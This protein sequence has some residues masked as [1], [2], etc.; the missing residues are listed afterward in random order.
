MT[1]P[2]ARILGR[3]ILLQS[4]LHLMTDNQAM[5]RFVWRGLAPVPG[6]N[7]TGM[8]ITGRL[9]RQDEASGPDDRDCGNLMAC[10]SGAADSST[11]RENYLAQFRK[12][13][14]VDCLPIESPFDLYGFLFFQITDS[15]IFAAYRPYIE[16]TLNLVALIIESNK[17]KRLLHQHKE[18]LEQ[19]VEARTRELEQSEEKY[20][21]LFESIRDAILVTDTNR[22]IIS[23]N[24]AVTDLFGYGRE[25]LKGNDIKLLCKD[26]NQYADL[27][28]SLQQEAD[29]GKA[30]HV[31]QYRKKSGTCFQGETNFFSFRDTKGEKVGIIGIIR[32]IT[33]RL[34]AGDALR[35]SEQRFRELFNSISD[36][37]FTQDLEGRLT[38]VNPAMNKGFGYTEEELLG[39]RVSDFMD[40]KYRPAFDSEY[41]AGIRKSGRSKGVS[42]FFRKDGSRIYIEYRSKL[43]TPNQGT[44]FIS[45]IGQDVSDRILAAKERKRLEAQLRQSQKMESIGTLSGGIAHDFNNMLSI[46]LGHTELAF[47]KIPEDSPAREFLCEVQTAGMRAR[48]VV[49]QLLTFSRKTPEA[50]EPLNLV[51]IVKEC[52]KLLRSTIAA[53]ID[54]RPDIDE[55]PAVL[56]ADATQIQQVLINLCSNA[57]DA[58]SETGGILRVSLA[59]EDLSRETAEFDPDLSA[60]HF[61]KITVRDTGEGIAAEH[62]NRIF[63]PYFTTKPV[64]KGTGMGLAMV[65]GIVKS[66]GGSI[67]VSSQPERGSVFEVFFPAVESAPKPGRSAFAE[68][69]RGTGRILLIE[70][71]PSLAGLNQ[72]RLE[73]LGYHADSQ[74][75][76]VEA[77]ELFRASPNLYDLVITDMTMPNMTGDQLCREILEIRPDMAIILCTGFSEKISEAS[78]KSLGAA[79]YLEKP[80]SM[81]DLAQS[82]HTLLSVP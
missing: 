10:L 33:W 45:G 47:E 43:V 49:R 19:A 1:D 46:I 59:F 14:Q 55:R 15:E 78:A 64:N 48:D 80:I 40:P 65:H 2:D 68:L 56:E 74:T 35:Q 11:Q 4:T 28:A 69:P 26:E 76:P 20:R 37:I 77:L 24:P 61:I 53:N 54:I 34:Q 70:D 30:F 50:R 73:K 42:S 29:E 9:Y 27:D 82:V 17:Q 18:H 62:L 52:L 5:A 21:S 57:A 67:R 44:P 60:G 75:D 12:N 71:D 38:S 81:G 72:K 25:E 16:N 79:K 7:V 31:L 36:L 63:D 51:P 58:M 39:R 6:L 3:I 22:S 8:F 13:H 41:L 23:C 32:D 66:H